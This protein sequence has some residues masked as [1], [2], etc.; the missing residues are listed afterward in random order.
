MAGYGD[1]GVLRV[2]GPGTRQRDTQRQPSDTTVVLEC[3][4]Y[5]CSAQCGEDC[6]R[7]WLVEA[8]G[9]RRSD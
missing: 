7:V 8:L 1:V 9:R 2:D 4:C 6:G 3:L 5:Q